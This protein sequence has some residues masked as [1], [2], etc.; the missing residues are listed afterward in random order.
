MSILSQKE[1]EKNVQNKSVYVSDGS[2]YKKASVCAWERWWL[3]PLPDYQYFDNQ[4]FDLWR[5]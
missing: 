4:N 5:F 3:V 2:V 1:T